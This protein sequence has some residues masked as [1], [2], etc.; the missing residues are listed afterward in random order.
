M[1]PFQILNQLAADGPLPIEALRAAGRDRATMAPVLMALI[2]LHLAGEAGPPGALFFA[3]HLLGEWRETAAY[4]ALVGLLRRPPDELDD[5]L[6]GAITE[7]SHRV[8]AAVFN[9]DPRPLYDLILDPAA[10]EFIRSQM[11]AAIAMVTHRQFLSREE[12]A[13]FLARCFDEL[14][15]SRGCFVWQGWANAIAMLGFLELEPLVREAYRRGRIDSSWSSLADFEKD[16]R[17]WTNDPSYRGWRGENHELFG[18]TVEEF[19]SW[20]GFSEEAAEARQRSGRERHNE[21]EMRTLAERV[22]PQPA[23]NPLKGIGRNDPCPC[24]SGRKFKKCCLDA[25]PKGEAIY[26]EP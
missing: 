3:F 10:D 1:E 23:F 18:D 17:D 2:E 26:K 7:T 8:I 12:A 6:G 25:R 16:L 21:A 24:G 13:G 5:I 15:P 19:S 11:C 22:L 9:G 4:P 14:R 20:Y